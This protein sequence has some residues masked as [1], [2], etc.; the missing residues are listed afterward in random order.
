[1]FVQV[2]EMLGLRLHLTGDNSFG[3]CDLIHRLETATAATG[4]PL[5]GAVER[6]RESPLIQD[7]QFSG[8]K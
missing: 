8:P 7:A 6:C 3:G 1:M 2:T 4:F 5:E